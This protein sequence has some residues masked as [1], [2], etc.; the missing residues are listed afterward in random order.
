MKVVFRVKL[1]SKGNYAI[2]ALLDLALHDVGQCI[3]LKDISRRIN[4]SENY[5]RQL[6]M[7]LTRQG[8]IGS[9][10][11][12]GG[13]YFLETNPCDIRLIDII[14]AVEGDICIVPCI[15]SNNCQVGQDEKECVAKTLWELLNAAIREQLKD[16]TLQE[17]VDEY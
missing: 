4:I 7:L 11:G 3:P 1:T 9:S 8:L 15:D 17:L 2:A 6:F 14:E 5:L 16:M 10:R 12:L 13:G